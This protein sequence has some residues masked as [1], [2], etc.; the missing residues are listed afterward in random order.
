MFDSDAVTTELGDL[1][2]MS[3]VEADVPKFSLCEC[4]KLMTTRRVR[5]VAASMEGLVQGVRDFC[6]PDVATI[7]YR[8]KASD[9]GKEEFLPGTVSGLNIKLCRCACPSGRT[10]KAEVACTEAVGAK[11]VGASVWREK[12]I[13][14]EFHMCTTRGSAQYHGVVAL[15]M[16]CD[17]A[18][19]NTTNTM[20]GFE[21]AH[22]DQEISRSED[23]FGARGV[24]PAAVVGL[25]I[26]EVE[27]RCEGE[28]V[29][30]A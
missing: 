23:R 28:A 26:G 8:P 17:Q 30:P 10:I 24:N 2:T 3:M 7:R 16:S 13:F 11:Q 18:A 20:R 29:C 15:P 9:I 25:V 27:L 5:C 1:G 21:L 14:D 4:A 12:N 22:V 6:E 19:T